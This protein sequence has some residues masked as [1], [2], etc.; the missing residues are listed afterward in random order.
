MKFM[1]WKPQCKA[2]S[3]KNI[4]SS[5]LDVLSDDR[6]WHRQKTAIITTNDIFFNFL[7]ILFLILIKQLLVFR[8]FRTLLHFRKKVFF[9]YINCVKILIHWRIDLFARR[10][11]NVSCKFAAG[12][13]G[14]GL[15][16]T[17]QP[18]PLGPVLVVILRLQLPAAIQTDDMRFQ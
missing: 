12:P 6:L 15:E 1:K 11:F 8:Y 14:I 16:P 18:G 9:D 4:C 3:I 2:R 5:Q 17:Y 7:S 10:G 13:V